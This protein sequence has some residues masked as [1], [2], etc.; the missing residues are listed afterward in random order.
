MVYF[1]HNLI[2]S[3][4]RC[5]ATGHSTVTTVVEVTPTKTK[6]P[7]STNLV[8]AQGDYSKIYIGNNNVFLLYI[9]YD[10]YTINL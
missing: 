1:Y 4:V 5:E 9:H 3:A 6:G 2:S 7:I 8:V 10:D